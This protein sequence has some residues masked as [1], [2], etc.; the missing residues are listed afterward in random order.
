MSSDERGFQNRK[1]ELEEKLERL[2]MERASLIEQVQA[3]REKR[4]LLDL[5]KKTGSIQQT[6][7]TLRKEKEELEGQ[8]SSLEGAQGQG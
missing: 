7:D 5:E 3:L 2:E 4:T 6:V 8:I 1:S